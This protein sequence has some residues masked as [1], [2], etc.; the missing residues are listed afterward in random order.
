[1]NHSTLQT[2]FLCSI[3]ALFA[4]TIAWLLCRFGEWAYRKMF[5]D[6]DDYHL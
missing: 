2:L 3:L 4:L 6:P 5:G 1:M